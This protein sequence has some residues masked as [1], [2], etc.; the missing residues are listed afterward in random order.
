MAVDLYIIGTGIL[1]LDQASVQTREALSKCRKV[2]HLTSNHEE[3]VSFCKDV[4]D[5]AELYW[6]GR[7]AGQVYR[8]IIDSVV[9]EVL[10]GPG[11]ANV[12]YGHPLFFDDINMGL[13]R[14][15]RAR[16]L[17]YE[18]LPGVSCLD[19]ISTDLEIDYGDGL[20]VYES[21]EMVYG[22]H[23]LNPRIH[24]LILQVAQFGSNLTV[25][26][27]PNE[28]GRLSRLEEH[29]AR[30][31]PKD[32][33]AIIVFS[34]RGDKFTRFRLDLTISELDENQEKI[35][36]GTTLYLPPLQRD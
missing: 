33:P 24:A 36:K 25:N 10:K 7:P 3:L 5:H 29:L 12:T 35:F 4:V 13:I 9:E 2:F 20:Q 15:M 32:H 19:T 18:V 16:G 11:V 6:T 26:K 1:G 21:Q 30:F 22:N 27:L 8:G 28:V 14:E 17:T 31:Y 34:D 23:P